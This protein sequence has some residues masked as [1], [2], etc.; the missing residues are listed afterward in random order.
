MSNEY[1]NASGY[2]A[3]RA[4]GASLNARNEFAAIAAAF[5][6]LPASATHANEVWVVNA[7]GTGVTTKPVGTLFAA[8][9]PLA[10]GTLTGGLVLN[11]G[12]GANQLQLTGD[13]AFLSGYDAAGTTQRG[14]LQFNAANVSLN[15]VG[16]AATLSLG[17]NGI[18]RLLIA[19]SGAATFTQGVAAAGFTGPLAGNANTATVLQT[20][21]NINGVAFNGSADITVPA[22]DSSKLPLTGG[23]LTGQ[24]SIAPV[25]GTSS[26][27]LNRATQAGGQTTLMLV[28]TDTAKSWQLYQQTGSTDLAIYSTGLANNILVLREAGTATFTGSLGVGGVTPLATMHVLGGE[29]RLQNDAFV[30]SGYNTAGT[31]RTG[32]LQFNSAGVLDFASENGSYQRWLVGGTERMRLDTSGRLGL[33][34]A[35]GVQLDVFGASIMSRVGGAS[36]NNLTQTYSN[37]VGL[38]LWAGGAARL[39][40]TGSLTISTNATLTTGIPTGYVDGMVLDAAGNLGVGTAPSFFLHVAKSQNAA[41]IARFV[42]GMSGAASRISLELNSDWGLGSIDA[43]A[44][45]FTGV[46]NQLWIQTQAGVPIIFGTSSTERMRITAAGL[47]QDAAANELGFKGLPSASV[48]TGAF[49]AADRGKCVYAT[50]G[51]TVPNATMA[52]G[53]VV[54]I[55]NTTAAAITITATVTTLRQAGTANTGNRTLA[56]FGIATVVFSSGTLGFISGTGL[57]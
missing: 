52:A 1:F 7:T 6:K 34:V 5:D 10:G 35:P 27:V 40:S 19:A 49:I 23:T 25:A 47:I 55:V 9:L 14:F 16:V 39:Y 18:A 15:A 24:L 13:G 57:T 12:A 30:L 46:G 3:P 41:T 53:D 48:T 26:L 51:V 42:N 22:V 50:A 38:G 32:Y 56:A 33:G 8:Y 29:A 11:S 43:Y 20:A 37:T 45:T 4:A 28:T 36:G 21:R 31:L 44:S 2:P 17:T 54:T